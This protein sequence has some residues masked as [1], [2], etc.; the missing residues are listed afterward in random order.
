M[1]Q[2]G[3]PRL[4]SLRAKTTPAGRGWNFSTTIWTGGFYYA[5]EITPDLS[6]WLHDPSHVLY[7]YV[8][9]SRTFPGTCTRVCRLVLGKKW[10][11]RS[12][13]DTIT[14]S[15][16][17]SALGAQYGGGAW[18]RT[19]VCITVIL[20]HE[21]WRAYGVGSCGTQFASNGV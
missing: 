6:F 9:P 16:R 1:L 3:C 14:F 11:K 18:I 4:S 19:I 12:S 10:I 17:P 8:I 7:L 15:S 20:L 21:T 2:R 13:F 5:L